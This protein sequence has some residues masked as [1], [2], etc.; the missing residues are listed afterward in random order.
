[1]SN[2]LAIDTELVNTSGSGINTNG[3]TFQEE[4]ENFY[5][6]KHQLQYKKLVLI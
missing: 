3:A 2:G 4:V 6:M 5:L 1:M